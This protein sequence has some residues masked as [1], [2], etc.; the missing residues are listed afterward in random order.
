[1]I[2]FPKNQ[3]QI[4]LLSN[5][6][7]VSST[8]VHRYLQMF[9]IS[10]ISDTA[11]INQL[12]H[13]LTGLSPM[14]GSS[15]G[16][17]YQVGNL[18]IKVSEACDPSTGQPHTDA[19]GRPNINTQELCIYAQRGDP[20]YRIPNTLYNKTNILGSNII[21]ENLVGM[22]IRSYTQDFTPSFIDIY[23]FQYDTSS[24][25]KPVYGI[26][27]MLDKIESLGKTRPINRYD[28]AFIM[29][30]LFHALDIAQQTNRYVHY[31]LY[32]ENVML[33]DNKGLKVNMF[34][35][36][37]GE[38]LYTYYEYDAVIIDHGYSRLETNDEIITPMLFM[39]RNMPDTPKPV[40]K[41]GMVDYLFDPMYDVLT[42]TIKFFYKLRENPEFKD[43][44]EY[45]LIKV[46]KARDLNHAISLLRDLTYFG[47]TKKTPWKP[48]VPEIHIPVKVSAQNAGFAGISTTK[49]M[50][51]HTISYIR[52]N[53]NGQIK[54]PFSGKEILITNFTHLL[55]HLNNTGRFYIS[56]QIIGNVNEVTKYIRPHDADIMDTTF[57]NYRIADQDLQFK[58]DVVKIK[59]YN[60]GKPNV[61]PTTIRDTV[62]SFNKT[63][64]TASMVTDPKTG[65]MIRFG[66]Q[67][68]QVAHIKTSE[69]LKSGYSFRFDCCY[70]FQNT[71]FHNPKVKS[72][73]SINVSFFKI[74][75]S[76]QLSLGRF[77]TENYQSD[78]KPNPLY[79]P[80]YGTI[81]I[82]T[83]GM[84]DIL[85][86]KEDID[87]TKYK[88]YAQAGPVLVYNSRAQYKSKLFNLLAPDG[89][90]MFRSREPSNGEANV[91]IFPDGYPNARGAIAPGEFKHA[92]NPNPRSAILIMR[93]NDVKFIQVEGRGNRGPGMDMLQL[94]DLCLAE[95]AVKAINVDG[96]GSSRLTWRG[97]GD[98][99]ITGSNPSA[100]ES[101][102][103]GSTLSFI[104]N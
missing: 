37:N 34:T 60:G 53:L 86:A 31:D 63:F 18:I 24:L 57:Y 83:N 30:E 27:E 13:T 26:M 47:T 95:G 7:G 54:D 88:Y 12:K 96:G 79:E 43:L 103:A 92:A 17:V 33:R 55:S 3:Q 71:I 41:R 5:G 61:Q 38:Y 2:N 81:V 74:E 51:S 91:A 56:D 8:S 66:P 69:G 85:D 64:A 35:L 62:E 75:N 77:K 16:K 78:I 101:Y 49:E 104:K 20:I 80:Y 65:N 67:W 46:F 72:G 6:R 98:T 97:I 1:M 22:L 21:L 82:K 68:Y 29:F 44:I 19:S 42:I 87:A 90:Y 89:S 15:V 23:G 45:L 40:P 52:A 11:F 50:V 36:G 73:V 4:D 93:N 9:S 39:N 32:D 10:D 58:D 100:I 94:T 84:L 76:N 14:G 28:I 99:E 70:I 59:L 48:K 25:S 102:P